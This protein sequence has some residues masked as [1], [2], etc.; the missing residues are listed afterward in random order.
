MENETTLNG[1][2]N[3]RTCFS[4]KEAIFLRVREYFFFFSSDKQKKTLNT[5]NSVW[6]FNNILNN[7]YQI[8][9]SNKSNNA[10]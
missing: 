5:L 6:L 7:T 2:N 1:H 10:Q 4:K 3:R 9:H 8:M